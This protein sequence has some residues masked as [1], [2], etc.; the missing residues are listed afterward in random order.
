MPR[1]VRR[2]PAGS[3]VFVD[4][5][6]IDPKADPGLAGEVSGVL[7]VA[8]GLAHRRGECVLALV[9][10][11][12]A[13]AD[14]DV[15]QVVAVVVDDQGDPRIA[16]DVRNPAAIAVSVECDVVLTKHVVDDDL[17]GRPIGPK[18]RQHRAPR[19]GKEAAHRLDQTPAVDHD[20]K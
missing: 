13:T 6:G 5:L 3:A 11:R 20:P 7:A 12:R 15:M 19:R 14:R 18:R 17:P 10:E 1:R 8:L 2:P 16:A 4:V 9:D